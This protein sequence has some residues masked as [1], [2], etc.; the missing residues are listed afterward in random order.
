M[1]ISFQIYYMYIDN[2]IYSQH[3]HTQVSLSF[4]VCVLLISNTANLFQSGDTLSRDRR[5]ESA[6]YITVYIVLNKHL[7][8]MF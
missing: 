2:V 1:R 4:Y 5:Y 3:T 7:F 8:Y 6:Q